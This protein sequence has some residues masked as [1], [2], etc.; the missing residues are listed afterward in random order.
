MQK[1][2]QYEHHLDCPSDS[3]A[4]DVRPRLD[5]ETGRYYWEITDT[6]FAAADSNYK[7]WKEE[8]SSATT[9]Y[10]RYHTGDD[11]NLYWYDTDD[12]YHGK[13][14]FQIF[15]EETGWNRSIWDDITFFAVD[16]P[17][18]GPSYG[19]VYP[20]VGTYAEKQVNGQGFINFNETDY[21]GQSSP[22]RIYFDPSKTGNERLTVESTKIYSNIYVSNGFDVGSTSRTSAVTVEPVVDGV[23]KTSG[24]TGYFSVGAFFPFRRGELRLREIQFGPVF[25]EKTVGDKERARL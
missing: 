16:T 6:M 20:P 18:N 9:E 11:Q 22:L 15:D 25:K 14:F 17:A 1:M 19:K 3:D 21:A 7:T 24:Q 23:V 12:K 13:S 2:K 5:A 10:G 8:N 4:A